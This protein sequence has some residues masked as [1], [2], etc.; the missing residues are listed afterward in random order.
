DLRGVRPRRRGAEARGGEL[1]AVLD[2]VGFRPELVTRREAARVLGNTS[3]RSRNDVAAL[4]GEPA[5]D[6]NPARGR[7]SGRLEPDLLA[8]GQPAGVRLQ[9]EHRRVE[10]LRT[11]ALGW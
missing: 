7:V 10:R 5:E 1:R 8:R 6:E 3:G 11:A 9:L 2:P 4:G